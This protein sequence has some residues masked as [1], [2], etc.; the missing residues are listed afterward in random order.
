MAMD[1]GWVVNEIV[2]LEGVIEFLRPSIL[3]VQCRFKSLNIIFLDHDK[4]APTT[5]ELKS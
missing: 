1:M 4:T 2:L 5:K 3:F